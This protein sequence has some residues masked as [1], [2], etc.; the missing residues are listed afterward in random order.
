MAYTS[1]GF[2]P[3]STTASNIPLPDPP[4]AANTT[5]MPLSYIALAMALPLA[6]SLKPLVSGGWLMYFTSTVASGSTCL[7]PAVKPASNGLMMS[8]ST[9]PMKP[10]LP[11]FDAQAAAAPTRNE[12]SLTPNTMD[13]TLGSGLPAASA[14]TE[15]MMAYCWVGFAVADAV[16]ASPHRKPLATT[17]AVL[18]TNAFMRSGRSL[19]SEAVGVDSWPVIP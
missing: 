12:A 18:P 13:R 10:S 9:P 2:F 8:F 17:R 14:T 15:S 11:D 1:P 3:V 4:A 7:A 5:S 16:V 6:G 19:P